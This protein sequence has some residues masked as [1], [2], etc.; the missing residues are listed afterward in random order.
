MHWRKTARGSNGKIFYIVSALITSAA[1]STIILLV[2]H[3]RT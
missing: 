3:Y 1:I 2:M